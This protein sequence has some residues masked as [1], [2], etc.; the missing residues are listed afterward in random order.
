MIIFAFRFHVGTINNLVFNLNFS[1]VC[2]EV[3]FSYIARFIVKGIIVSICYN[4]QIFEVWI[5]CIS[6]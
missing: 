2:S 3:I 5:F 1:F 4:E 6:V